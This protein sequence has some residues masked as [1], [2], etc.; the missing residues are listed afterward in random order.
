[1]PR[2]RRPRKQAGTGPVWDW[3]KKAARNTHN[4]VKDN[5]LISRG[6][7][8]LAPLAGPYSGTITRIGT[9]AGALG[10]GRRPRRPRKRNK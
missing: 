7:S 1:M 3:I 10:Y 4:F 8:A 9:T 2:K 5:R 6:A